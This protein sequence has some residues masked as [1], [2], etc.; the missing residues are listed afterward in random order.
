MNEQDPHRPDGASPALRA[1]DADRERVVEILR[2]AAGEGRL[3][4]DELEARIADAYRMRTLAELT[5]L[6][7][8]VSPAAAPAGPPPARRPGAGT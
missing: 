6:T 4:P 2:G 3:D 7:A 5:A 1:S 8:D